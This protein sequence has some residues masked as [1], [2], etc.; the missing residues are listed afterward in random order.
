MALTWESFGVKYNAEKY[1]FTFIPFKPLY[2]G[3][4]YFEVWRLKQNRRGDFEMGI[5]IIR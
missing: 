1:P 5:G 4:L 3:F 2:M